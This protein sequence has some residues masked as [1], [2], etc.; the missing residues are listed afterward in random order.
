M[1][2]YPI[3]VPENSPF[4]IQNI[5]F[6][7]F[8]DEA[9]RAPR[10]ATVIGN[11]VLDLALLEYE[12]LF[13]T[14]LSLSANSFS[15]PTLNTFAALGKDVRRKVREAIIQILQDP[16]SKLFGSENLN[17]RAFHRLE[18]VNMHLPMHIPAFTDFSCFEEHVGNCFALSNISFGPESNFY[19][20]PMAY[21]GRA[22][23][24]LPSG[25]SFPRPR[26]V[27]K[28]PET[29]IVE[30]Q[31]VRKLDYEMELGI[32]LSTSLPFG[33]LLDP[34]TAED[35]IFGYVLLNDWSARDIQMY[36][37][38]PAGPFN[39]K[40]FAS[41]ISPWVVV[42]EA[43]EASR[44]SPF[45][46]RREDP[47][48]HVRHTSLK[49]KSY[50]I[51]FDVSITRTGQQPAHVST[52]NYKHSYF[53]PA[54]CIAHRASSGCGLLTGELLGGGTVSSP[55]SDWPDRSVARN[56]CLFEITWDGTREVPQTGGMYLN[57]FDS[58]IM[59]AWATGIENARIGFG[60]L[61][62]TVAPAI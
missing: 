45:H 18:D 11:W 58:V 25:T 13:D 37:S 55:E 15:Q 52:S 21:N 7:I 46:Q 43:L 1:P 32:L 5:P 36:E 53:T 6:G 54:Q 51:A 61:V 62:G 23:S 33:Q 29:G 9:N 14:V 49:D 48:V 34:D 8:S 50:D 16:E 20:S 38:M 47:P 57:D 44:V 10:A 26:G 42:P 3:Q 22:S 41:H 28:T 60:Q 56:G 39:C 24:I 19:K 40:A 35:Y 4:P 2:A 27:F 30:Y 31:A 17:S 59:E 12:G